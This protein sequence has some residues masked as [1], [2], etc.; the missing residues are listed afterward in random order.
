MHTDQKWRKNQRHYPPLTLRMNTIFHRQKVCL[1][2]HRPEMGGKSKYKGHK[3]G[4]PLT[5]VK[6]QKE[7]W[8]KHKAKVKGSFARIVPRP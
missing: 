8:E 1:F 5:R 3:N 2:A 7:K 6:K 4:P